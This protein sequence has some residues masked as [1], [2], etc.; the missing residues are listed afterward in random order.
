MKAGK[1]RDP[2][3]KPNTSWGIDQSQPA[4]SIHMPDKGPCRPIAPGLGYTIN[5]NIHSKCKEK[6]IGC[7]E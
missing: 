2:Q 7:T 5:W 6:R 4:I 3:F 1:D